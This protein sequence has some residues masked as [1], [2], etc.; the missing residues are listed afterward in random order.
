MTKKVRTYISLPGSTLAE[1]L[2]VP[3]LKEKEI[4]LK[5]NR[6][7]A[8]LGGSNTRHKSFLQCHNQLLQDHCS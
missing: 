3:E 8:A 7:K 2:R 5:L 6:Y 1:N 4:Q